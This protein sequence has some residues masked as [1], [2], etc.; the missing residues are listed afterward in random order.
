MSSKGV[1]SAVGEGEALPSEGSAAG[2]E[3]LLAGVEVLLAGVGESA[4]GAEHPLSTHP[5]R[6]STANGT[7][8]KNLLRVDVV[9]IQGILPGILPGHLSNPY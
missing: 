4:G 6:N 9:L 1:S 7:V 8:T 2:R 3:P 5:A